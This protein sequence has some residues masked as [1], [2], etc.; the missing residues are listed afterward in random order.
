MNTHNNIDAKRSKAIKQQ[1]LE[2]ERNA[3]TA[4]RS[5]IPHSLVKEEKKPVI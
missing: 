3:R 2:E 4:K 5:A 1:G